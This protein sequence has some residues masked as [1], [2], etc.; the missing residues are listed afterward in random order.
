[1]LEQ[2]DEKLFFLRDAEDDRAVGASLRCCRRTTDTSMSRD[3]VYIVFKKTF[4]S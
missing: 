2:N 3:H 4:E 1:M